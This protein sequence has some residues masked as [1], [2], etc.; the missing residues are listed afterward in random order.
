GW[1]GGA[2]GRPGGGRGCRGGRGTAVAEMGSSSALHGDGARRR[3]VRRAVAGGCAVFRADECGAHHGRG[4]AGGGG[5]ACRTPGGPGAPGCQAGQPAARP[6]RPC[7]GDRLRNRARLG[8]GAGTAETAMNE[9]AATE[10][11]TAML[12]TEAEGGRLL[13]TPWRVHNRPRVRGAR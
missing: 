5:P 11:A 13:F 4:R 10:T 12:A 9:T 3:A 8:L 2:A 7:E 1:R 6:G